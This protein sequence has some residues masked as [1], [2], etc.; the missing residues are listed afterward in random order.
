MGNDIASREEVC[1]GAAMARSEL[2]GVCGTGPGRASSTDALTWCPAWSRKLRAGS[3]GLSAGRDEDSPLQGQRWQT[4]SSSA[5]SLVMDWKLKSP[6]QGI[7]TSIR[8][9]LQ[10]STSQ[11]KINHL[12]AP[13]RSCVL[14]PCCLSEA[15]GRTAHSIG[16]I[17]KLW[18]L[19]QEI[20]SFP[21]LFRW[22][23][24]SCRQL[25]VMHRQFQCYP[26]PSRNPTSKAN[27]FLLLIGCAWP[28][29][30]QKLLPG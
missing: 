18:P 12:P 25:S 17:P 11:A 19:H 29:R 10:S 23:L 6:Q 14:T 16:N 7:K 15:G 26:Y 21:L 30:T 27:C 28:T 4:G 22:R 8:L 13:I 20:S 2:R 5:M 24:L 1:S 3:C 9:S